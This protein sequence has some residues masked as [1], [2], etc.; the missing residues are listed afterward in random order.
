MGSIA[1]LIK[2]AVSRHLSVV[3]KRSGGPI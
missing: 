3:G 1:S 2:V